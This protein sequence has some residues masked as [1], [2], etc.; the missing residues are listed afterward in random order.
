MNASLLRITAVLGL[1]CA[2]FPLVTQAQNEGGDKAGVAAPPSN[3]L[4]PEGNS[5]GQAERR[6]GELFW[7]NGDTLRGW[8]VGSGDADD[9]RLVWKSDL[10]AEQLKLDHRRLLSVKF[11]IDR[12]RRATLGAGDGDS[13]RF[14]VITRERNSIDGQL[15]G[16]DVDQIYLRHSGSDRPLAIARDQVAE[17]VGLDSPDLLLHGFNRY[18]SWDRRS[19]DDQSGSGWKLAENGR[20]ESSRW[21]A[22]YQFDFNATGSFMIDIQ[23]SSAGQRPDFAIGLDDLKRGLRLETWQEELVINFGDNFAPVLTLGAKDRDLHLVIGIDSEARKAYVYHADGRRLADLDFSESGESWEVGNALIDLKNKGANLTVGRLVVRRWTPNAKR[24][25]PL[26]TSEGIQLSDGTV[27]AGDLD[28]LRLDN[29][30]NLSIG[31]VR[32]GENISLAQLSSISMTRP[33]RSGRSSR[34]AAN[35]DSV[36]FSDGQYLSGELLAIDEDSIR[37]KV[38]YSKAPVELSLDGVRSVTFGDRASMPTL[39]SAGDHLFSKGQHLNG[40]I[41]DGIELGK[42]VAWKCDGAD[43]VV[44]IRD[45]ANSR[46]VR[47]VLPG[48]PDES[49]HQIDDQ[50]DRLVLRSNEIVACRIGGI[51]QQSV[52]FYRSV[53]SRDHIALEH[54]KAIELADPTGGQQGFD[55]VRWQVLSTDPASI[56]RTENGLSFPASKN[57]KIG[58]ASA[59]AAREVNF[60]LSFGGKGQGGAI[61]MSLF[62][63]SADDTEQSQ[64]LTILASGSRVW[65]TQVVQGQPFMFSNNGLQGISKH[66]LPVRLQLVEQRVEVYID[67]QIALSIETGNEAKAGRALQFSVDPMSARY[68]GPNSVITLS[69]LKVIR[70]KG[71][72]EGLRVSRQA[73]VE[74]LTVPRFRKANPQD[75]VLIAGNGDLLRGQLVAASPSEVSFRSRLDEVVLPR[76]RIAGLIWL[77]EA[78]N[79]SSESARQSEAVTK[80]GELVVILN[81]GS[82]IKL[83][84]DQLNDEFL[85]GDSQLLGE[86]RIPMADVRE[87]RVGGFTSAD[88]VANEKMFYADWQLAPAQEPKLPGDAGEG[89]NAANGGLHE[90]GGREAGEVKLPLLEGDEFVLS[91]ARGKIVVLDFWATW[92]GPCVKAIPEYLEAVSRFDS[93]RVRF[94]GVN[95]SE[96]AEVITAFLKRRDWKFDVALDQ[97][98]GVGLSYGVTGIPHTVVID[99]E[100]KVAWVHTGYTPDGATAMKQVIESLLAE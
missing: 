86:C 36:S 6:S 32:R 2:C 70:E 23:L 91:K 66:P 22:R 52:H 55:D 84:A 9:A 19:A 76:H 45:G 62:G 58:H 8:I 14:R 1:I 11:D 37:L 50:L 69:D 18:G 10:F 31:R 30:G 60:K 49:W 73:Q 94:V 33:T 46:L 54:V 56:S 57:G 98:G 59:L 88:F 51:D 5:D 28:S 21:R 29:S 97:N 75:H 25:Q 17:I 47:G 44:T 80:E 79:L 96:S 34:G 99:G 42:V 12:S 92:C 43:N 89:G 61:R 15:V 83:L 24:P 39:K 100:G 63:N 35:D 4:F 16:I 71:S 74:A 68:G 78:A 87:L 64:E 93:D 65:A 81:D 67:D 53:A 41:V 82:R 95:Q 26:S 40:A 72:H 38:G 13:P 90:R 7:K 20:F 3:E 85:S 48:G 77:D 27:I